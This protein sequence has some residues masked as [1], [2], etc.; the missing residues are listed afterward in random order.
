[1][2]KIV[3]CISIMMQDVYMADGNK[4]IRNFLKGKNRQSKLN[5]LEIYSQE[6]IEVSELR[7]VRY[8]SLYL[9]DSCSKL[10]GNPTLQTI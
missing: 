3:S 8:S 7:T 9:Q 10:L 6:S 1:M 4:P 5:I 2:A